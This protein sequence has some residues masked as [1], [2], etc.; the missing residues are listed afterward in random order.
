MTF[1]AV[2]RDGMI[3]INTHGRLP[4]GT[5][6]EVLPVTPASKPK[7]PSKAR[8]RGPR[9]PTKR[10]KAEPANPL[11]AIAGIWKDRPDWKG[12]STL[13][14]QRELREKALGHRRGG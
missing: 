5:V 6:V 10:G 13:E 9:K 4:D 12:K 1:R 8:S 2:V 14:I 11:L 3:N 7:G